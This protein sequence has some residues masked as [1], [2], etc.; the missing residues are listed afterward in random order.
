MFCQHRTPAAYRAAVTDWETAWQEALYGPRGFY[1]RPEGPAGHFATS[2]Q[3]LGPVAGELLAEALLAL[4]E[5]HGLSRV[6]DVGAGRGEL[7]LALADTA[8][9]RET[10]V[11]LLGVDVVDHPP[12]L[13][14]RADWLVSPGGAKLPPALDGLSDTLV[15]AHEWLDVVPCPVVELDPEGVWRSLEVTTDGTEHLG[16]PL[17]GAELAWLQRWWPGPGARRAEVGLTRDRAFADLVARVDRGVVLA[18]DYGHTRDDR[19][20]AGSLTAYRTGVQVTPVPDGTCDLTADVA[21]DSLGADL[22]LTQRAALRSLLG[23]SAAPD[24]ALAST[25]PAGYL[26]QLGRSSAL[27]ALSAPHGLGAF[28]WALSGRGGIV[29]G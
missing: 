9:R 10:P 14:G 27:A 13:P 11:D 23:G 19:P 29:L 22:V 16:P 2:T 3:G 6:V 18:V 28:W 8:S 25:D 20:A 17:G 5:H 1:R 15:V 4:A 24:H 26:R 21:V 7:L 12:L